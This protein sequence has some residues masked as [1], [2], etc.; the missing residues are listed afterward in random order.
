M[1]TTIDYLKTP[2]DMLRY[3]CLLE[4]ELMSARAFHR[5]GFDVERDPA[6]GMTLVEVAVHSAGFAFGYFLFALQK[7]GLPALPETGKDVMNVLDKIG[8]EVNASVW[9]RAVAEGKRDRE[10]DEVIAALDTAY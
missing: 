2:L 10:S 9:E 5:L 4:S 3:L 8:K 7:S 1:N 6:S